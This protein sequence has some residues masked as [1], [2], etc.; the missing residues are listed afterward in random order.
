MLIFDSNFMLHRTLFLPEF[1]NMEYAGKRTGGVFGVLQA[2]ANTFSTCPQ[3]NR[4]IM[5]WDGKKSIRRMTMYPEYKGNRTA[6]NE[7][8]KAEKDQHFAIFN[9]QKVELRDKF[10]PALGM[11]SVTF[12]H[13]EADDVIFQ[14]C[15][16][17]HDKEEILVVSEDG[18]LLQ[19]IAHFP[20]VKILQP[21]KKRVVRKD[22]FKE[23]TGLPPEAFIYYKAMIGD[24]SDNITNVTGIGEKTALK[25]LD[26]V[27][28][29]NIQ[30]SLFKLASDA[31]QHYIDKKKGKREAGLFNDWKTLG[32]NLDLV[33]ISREPFL[34]SEIQSL[35]SAIDLANP[36]IFPEYFRSLCVEY[37]FRSILD[38]F[39]FWIAPFKLV[40]Y[41]KEALVE[42]QKELD[43]LTGLQ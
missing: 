16:A 29:N 33:D 39:D 32:R 11:L 43:K 17:Y 13:K 24:S 26:Q 41:D 25:F 4:R 30:D 7:Q 3:I 1:F 9:Q 14:I 27:D 40:P 21:I 8:E 28:I 12:P 31:N 22:N 10:L 20:T 6:K 36:S 18:D 19:I 5:V 23:I 2:V 15:K 42:M 34:D 37:G 35:I 38:K